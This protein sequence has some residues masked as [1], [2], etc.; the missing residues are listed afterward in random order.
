MI[1][2]PFIWPLLLAAVLMASVALYVRRFQDAPAVRPFSWLMWLTALWALEYAINISTASLPAKIFLANLRASFIAFIPF[3]VLNLA[4]EYVGKSAWLTRRRL[5]ILLSVP[6]LIIIAAWSSA[7]HPLYRYNFQLNLN[8][9]FPLLVWDKGPIYWVSLVY[10]L[11]LYTGTFW[12]LITAFQVRALHFWNTLCLIF[13]MLIPCLAD[14]LYSL[15]ITPWRGYN[16][17]PTTFIFT[18]GLYLWALLRFRMFSVSPVARNAVMDALT[19]LV[20]VF[21]NYDHLVDF[22]RAA[23][24]VIGL[25]PAAIGATPTALP[26]AW[27]ALLQRYP[28]LVA[29]KEEVTIN[30]CVYDLTISPVQDSRRRPLGRLF[31]LHDTTARQQTEESLRQ[32]EAQNRALLNAMPD[33]VFQLA[34]NG[35]FLSVHGRNE[36]LYVPPESIVGRNIQTLLPPEVATITLEYI[37]QTLALNKIQVYEYKLPMAA[38]AAD[39]EARMAPCGPD[40]VLTL[41]RDVTAH[42]HVETELRQLSRAV[43]QSASAIVITDRNGTIEFVNPAFTRITGYTQAEA[44]GQN[45]HILKSNYHPP[46]FYREMWRTLTGGQVWQ[47]EIH[48]KRKDGVLYWESATISPIRDELGQITHYVA[49][50]DDITKQKQMEKVLRQS[51]ERYRLVSELISDFAY[52]F[53]LEPDNQIVPEWITQAFTT[54]TG[55]TV[56]EMAE[57]DGIKNLMHPDDEPI[58]RVHFQTLLAGQPDTSDFRIITKD[59]DARWLRNYARPVWDET[60]GRVV[61]IYGG[62]RDITT[63]RQAELALHQRNIQLESLRHIALELSAELELNSLLHSIAK[64]AGELLV[65]PEGEFFIYRP[66]ENILEQVNQSTE[67]IAAGI[68]PGTIRRGEGL[69]GKVLETRQPVIINDYQNWADAIPAYKNAGLAT[70]VGM[71]IQWGDEFLG[72]LGVGRPQQQPF[73]QA[74]VELLEMFAAHAAL[75][76]NNARLVEQTRQ[77]AKIKARLLQEVNHRVKNNLAAIIGLLY[78]EQQHIR[79]A[80]G[81]AYESILHDLIQRVDGLATVHQMLSAAQ[82]SPLPLDDLTR[83]VIQSCLQAVPTT[84]QVQVNVIQVDSGLRVISD[85]AHSLALII[86]EL[87][88]NTVKYAVPHR[89]LTQITVNI[90]TEANGETVVFEYRDNGPGYPAEVLHRNRQNVGLDLV[91]NITR[92]NLEGEMALQNNSGAVTMLRFKT[93]NI[94][95]SPS[96]TYIQ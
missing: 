19:D 56:D 18:G 69:V 20:L 47:S 48:N 27:A 21:D 15:G 72:V 54:I 14:L 33:I 88:T 92:S 50:K 38:G 1:Y 96:K 36:A 24:T 83:Q 49:V 93:A 25:S 63:R 79:Q 31:L 9:P 16:L 13:G 5:T 8:S 91:E 70:V 23:Q 34:R 29:T 11:V 74:D 84:R 76:L 66:Q 89:E 86:N 4:L 41:V 28:N 80:G 59:G 35:D 37:D 12:L 65:C 85:Q 51:E 62:V 82:W 77:D 10:T 46:E 71:P 42:K 68:K 7:Y 75:A 64:Q 53:H 44:I 40:K 95:I 43:E 61:R 45:P 3:T 6:A 17:A 57:P 2:T 81:E 26:P 22:N 94:T 60:R 73:S 90:A 78:T 39:Y 55:F 67:S 30:Q 32:S 58:I 52:A 87:A